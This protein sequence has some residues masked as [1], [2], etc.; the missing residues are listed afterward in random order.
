MKA[1]VYSFNHSFEAFDNV[2]MVKV[3]HTNYSLIIMEDYLPLI[4]EVVGEVTIVYEDS[5][6]KYDNII[7]YYKVTNNVFEMVLDDIN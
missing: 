4:G 3:N 1:K 5:E 7:G 6:R 2:L